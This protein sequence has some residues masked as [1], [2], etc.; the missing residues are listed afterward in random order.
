M[1]AIHRGLLL[2]VRFMDHQRQPNLEVYFKKRR[3][4]LS[5]PTEF[6]RDPRWF[7]R[8]VTF[9][10]LNTVT[11]PPKSNVDAGDSSNAL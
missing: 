1:K 4:F 9:E 5:T 3:S 7:I 8:T 2:K 6:Q 11:M 10:K